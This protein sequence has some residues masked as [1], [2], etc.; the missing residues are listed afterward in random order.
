MEKKKKFEEWIKLLNLLLALFKLLFIY[1]GSN[2]RI[3]SN[4]NFCGRGKVLNFGLSEETFHPLASSV[5]L[6]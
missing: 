2:R 4:L 5:W 6:S 3:V 1:R